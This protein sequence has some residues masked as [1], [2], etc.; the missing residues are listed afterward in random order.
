MP[1]NKE[2]KPIVGLVWFYNLL[3]IEGNIMSNLVYTYILD[4]TTYTY[5]YR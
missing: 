4:I 3:A 1:L 2:T 5:I